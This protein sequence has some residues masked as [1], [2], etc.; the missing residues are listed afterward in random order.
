MSDNKIGDWGFKDGENYLVTTQQ[1]AGDLAEKVARLIVDSEHL[2][3]D[4]KS[5]KQIILTDPN[6]IEL[7]ESK[8]QFDQLKLLTSSIEPCGTT[9]QAMC[10]MSLLFK[11]EELAK[12]NAELLADREI[13]EW[14][15]GRDF[16]EVRRVIVDDGNSKT[17]R[18][19][20]TDAMKKEQK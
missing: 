8:R 7:L 17:L 13:V 16:D 10:Y 5:I 18:E 15:R 3:V 12:Q 14:F 9:A 11:Y 4:Y 2:P 20:I 6:I 19:A 1:K